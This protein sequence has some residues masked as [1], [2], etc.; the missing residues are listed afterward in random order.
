[1]YNNEELKSKGV[2]KVLYEILTLPTSE[3]C[4]YG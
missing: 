4:Q 2:T 1:L 3:A